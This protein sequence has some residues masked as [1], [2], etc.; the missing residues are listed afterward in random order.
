MDTSSPSHLIQLNDDMLYAICSFI[1]AD[2]NRSDLFALSK[3]SLF[4]N[5]AVKRDLF[6]MI[7]IKS[8]GDAWQF[9]V[10]AGRMG[11]FVQ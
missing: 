1:K 7:T 6:K 2:N 4:F 3:T 9:S 11:S 5:E 10:Q 8:P